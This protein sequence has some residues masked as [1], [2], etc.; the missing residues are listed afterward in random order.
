MD[1]NKVLHVA[2]DAGRIILE[3]GGETYR[4]EETIG[5]ICNAFGIDDAESFATPTGII[6]SIS[7]KNEKTYS[8]VRR[9][10]NRTL[11]L[12]KIHEVNNLARNIVDKKYT[13]DEVMN[14]LKKIDKGIRYSEI[15]TILWSAI[16][17]GSFS[18][19]FNGNI[20]DFFC[21]F[22]IGLLLKKF[23]ILSSNLSINQ[24]FI[25]SIGGAIAS[26][27]AL[28]LGKINI[29]SSVDSVTIGSIMLLVPG[30]AITNAIRDTIA[31]DFLSG[32]IRAAEA[33]LIAVSIAAGSGLVFK[34][35]LNIFGGF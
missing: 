15:T 35:W 31:G 14:E 27:L 23:T 11:N 17:A 21:A 5:R 6:V 28:S 8:L 33:F 29:A 7:D 19:L 13:I 2:T 12:Q 26:L 22:F 32:L 9:V 4:V 10:Q 30:L 3:N 34:L 1:L 16:A 24:F 20:K 18:L 25:N